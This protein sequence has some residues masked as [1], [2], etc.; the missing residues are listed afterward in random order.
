M[1]RL[2]PEGCGLRFLLIRHPF[3]QLVRERGIAAR[4]L[5]LFLFFQIPAHVALICTRRFSALFKVKGRRAPP[6]G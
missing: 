6:W 1:A 5:L 2:L 4:G 3:C